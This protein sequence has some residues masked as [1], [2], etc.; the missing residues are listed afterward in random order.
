MDRSGMRSTTRVTSHYPSGK[1]GKV[2]KDE[3]A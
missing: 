1:E 3:I 2:D